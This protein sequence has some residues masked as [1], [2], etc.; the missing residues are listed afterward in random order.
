MPAI[1][2]LAASTARLA[3]DMAR[4]SEEKKPAHGLFSL[5]ATESICNGQGLSGAIRA[6]MSKDMG[7]N[8]IVELVSK[9]RYAHFPG[10]FSARARARARFTRIT[11]S[12]SPLP[13]ANTRTTG[14]WGGHIV[15]KASPCGQACLAVLSLESG[16]DANTNAR[17]RGQGQ[18]KDWNP[19]LL[20]R[21]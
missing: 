7:T 12:L 18:G 2:R 20:P 9:A 6:G 14:Q 3:P 1:W 21:I 13:I 11:A 19:L 15:Q 16:E 8:Q 10:A 17:Q 5:R 4:R